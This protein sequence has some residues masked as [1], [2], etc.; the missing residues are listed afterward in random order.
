MLGTTAVMRT[1][2]VK[3]TQGVFN[4]A[5]KKFSKWKP[6]RAPGEIWLMYK[7]IKIA[8]AQARKIISA[9]RYPGIS[10]PGDPIPVPEDI[11]NDLIRGIIE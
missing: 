4:G 5:G 2:P 6:K 7:D 8:Q 10:K 1:N 9:W 11:K 3:K